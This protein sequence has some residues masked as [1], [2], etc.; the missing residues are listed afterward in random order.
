M[1]D[2]VLLHNYYAAYGMMGA[3]KFQILHKANKAWAVP[4]ICPCSHN[5]QTQGQ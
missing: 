5:K 2:N 4:F 1:V 3:V